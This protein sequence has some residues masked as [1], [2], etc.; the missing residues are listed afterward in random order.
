MLWIRRYES[1]ESEM[2]NGMQHFKSVLRKII[3]SCSC[4]AWYGGLNDKKKSLKIN[5]I[6]VPMI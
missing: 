5:I 6:L 1:S 3:L 2:E 4:I